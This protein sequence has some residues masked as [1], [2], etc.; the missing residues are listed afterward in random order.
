MRDEKDLALIGNRIRR[1]VRPWIRV[2]D[3]KYDRSRYTMYRGEGHPIHDCFQTL[4]DYCR[5][6]IWFEVNI[7]INSSL[8]KIGLFLTYRRTRDV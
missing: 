2:C 7:V 4:R 8:V 6:F 3:G 5:V 1:A